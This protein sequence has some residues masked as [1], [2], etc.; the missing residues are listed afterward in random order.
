LHFLFLVE[1][2]KLL[3][4]SISPIIIAG[5]LILTYYFLL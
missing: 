1:I 3:T 2:N 5:D 4:H